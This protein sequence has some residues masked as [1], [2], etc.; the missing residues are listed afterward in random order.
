MYRRAGAWVAGVSSVWRSWAR[1]WFSCMHL[2][3][4]EGRDE[5][6]N[7]AFGLKPSEMATESLNRAGS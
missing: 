2:R 7:A 3:S 6:S 1:V 4:Y 5:H